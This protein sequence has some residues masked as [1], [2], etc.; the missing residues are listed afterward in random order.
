MCYKEIWIQQLNKKEVKEQIKDRVKKVI[1]ELLTQKT[2]D[3]FSYWIYFDNNGKIFVDKTKQMET[4]D[5]RERKKEN[6][7]VIT[8]FNTTDEFLKDYIENLDYWFEY[9]IEIAMNELERQKAWKE[10]FRKRT[11]NKLEKEEL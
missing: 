4:E 10:I 11:E 6:I 2:R 5:F 7:F 9:I 1:N 8:H 3:F